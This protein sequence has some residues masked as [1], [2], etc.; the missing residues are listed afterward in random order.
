MA[1]VQLARLRG[2]MGFEKLVV[3]KLVHEHLASQKSFVGMLMQE[4]RL[5]ALVKHPN[6]VD[7][8]DLGESDGRYFVAM[9]YL[10]GEPM[11]AI[12]RAGRDGKRLDPLSTARLIAEVAEGLTAAHELR[13]MTGEPMPLVHH[14]ISQGN[15]MVLYTGQAKL[16][17]FGVAKAGDRA[18]PDTVDRIKGKFGYIAPE[19]LRGQM[20]DPRSDLFSLG[21]VLW[22]ALT[23]R[24]LFRADT[25]IQ[26]IQQVLEEPIPPPS[27]VNG[28]VPAAF[29]RICEKAL[30]RDSHRRYQSAA[31]IAIDLEAVLRQYAYSG[32]YELIARYM[33]QTFEARIRARN[34]I[35]SEATTPRGPSEQLVNEAFAIR[36][37]TPTS[38]DRDAAPTRDAADAHPALYPAIDNS[39]PLQTIGPI[40][41]SLSAKMEL[42][43]RSSLMMKAS[44]A[45]HEDD[46]PLEHTAIDFDPI[47]MPPVL[48]T[49]MEPPSIR[50]WP[51]Q[52]TSTALNAW[53]S[54]EPDEPSV[55]QIVAP[56][57]PDSPSL[58]GAPR[59]FGFV[60]LIRPPKPAIVA[61]EDGEKTEVTPSPIAPELRNSLAT[62][63]TRA[64]RAQ[65]TPAVAS[66]S[67]ATVETQP[68]VAHAATEAR[69]VPA[70]QTT[71]TVAA[72]SSARADADASSRDVLAGWGWSTDSVSAVT[73][74]SVAS[75]HY[76]PART[77]RGRFTA[78]SAIVATV[79]GLAV[80]SAAVA[81]ARG[82]RDDTASPTVPATPLAV[83]AAI[84]VPH[85]STRADSPIKATPPP[86]VPQAAA[87]D[88]RSTS[89]AGEDPSG[90]RSG[91]APVAAAIPR[92]R[93]SSERSQK[94]AEFD[95]SGTFKAGQ[96]EFLRGDARAA[97]TTFRKVIAASP[98]F[99]PAWRGSALALERLGERAAAAR[100][101]RR[102]LKLAPNAG[103]TAQIRARLERLE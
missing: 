97:L 85:D 59:S 77:L 88:T 51:E 96:S 18:N 35:I 60:K 43:K 61:D 91:D 83:A 39:I 9:E 69:P 20:G 103:D 86:D 87:P 64:A 71:A 6:V 73:S 48:P 84:P 37:L 14:D 8:Y 81:I 55:T 49:K 1:E 28:E 102:Y 2:A 21:V 13:S 46:G 16:V 7:I 11:L 3:I 53:P 78:R 56:R 5:A 15:I 50:R 99:A 70:V 54:D 10:A 82:G 63:D 58:P 101:L 80:V 45:E 74:A 12:L 65:P 38:F 27:H 100:A 41:S 34:Q 26:T 22:E 25:D 29:D 40:S 72:P 36:P 90:P 94:R 32:K 68:M 31:E 30:Q 98:G 79:A 4:A 62:A 24:R 17:D 47:P 66:P 57:T 44:A 52:S 75:V 92:S 42:A 23:L 33:Q 93:T 89:A 67:I 95:V 76:T 19:K